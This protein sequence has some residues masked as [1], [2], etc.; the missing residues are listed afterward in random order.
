MANEQYTRCPACRTIFRVTTAQ[1]SLRAGQVRCGHCRT[2]FDGLRERID[3]APAG[4][5]APAYDELAAGPATVTLRSAAALDP[6][7]QPI[8]REPAAPP[9]DTDYENRFAW[10][11]RKPSGV[12]NVLLGIAAPLLILALLLQ[13][14]L[15]FR[16]AV[17]AQWPASKP[18]LA[19]MCAVTGCAIRPMRD[20][21][22]LSIDASDL[23][24]DPAHQGLLVLT[25]TVRNRASFEVGYP[26][27]EL[28][29]TDDRDKEVVRRA[30]APADY[31]GGTVDVA[32]GIPGNS[33]LLVKVF[34]DASATQQAGYRLY[35]FYP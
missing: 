6:P 21:A 23:Q 32:S 31:V 7:P 11:R 22:A 17:A 29:L 3:L 16:D 27:L 4:P 33:E 8:A 5:A 10:N 30:L 1:L 28:T 25:A 18:F 15:H 34:I 20:V 19:K 14:A 24:A 13:A 9:P 12:L 26:Y 35:L 2:A